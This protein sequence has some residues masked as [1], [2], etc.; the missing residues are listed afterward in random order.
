MDADLMY[1]IGLR[2]IHIVGGTCWVGGAIIYHLFLEPTAKATAQEGRQFMQYFILRRRYPVYMTVSSLATN[3][4]GALL[5][6]RT[7]DGL[8]LNWLTSGPGLVFSLGSA[9][10]FVALGMGLFILSPTAKR[11]V[12][13][14]QAIQTAGGPPLPQQVSELH[15]LETKMS[16]VGWSEFVLMLMSLMA[17]TAARYWWF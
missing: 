13:L 6:W 1:L 4:S 11:L 15:H 2:I 5:L 9:L 17:M 10:A 7:S 8:S 12:G 3:L 16:L 14:G